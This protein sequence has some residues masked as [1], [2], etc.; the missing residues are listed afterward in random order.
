MTAAEKPSRSTASAPPAGTWFASA[1]RM[2]SEPSRRISLMQQADRIVIACRRIGRSW[3]TRVPRSRRFYARR[4]SRSGAHFVQRLPARQPAP[5]ARRLPEPARPPP[6][7]CTWWVIARAIVA[8]AHGK[9]PCSTISVS[10]LRTRKPRVHLRTGAGAA[11][12]EPD[13]PGVPAEE[14]GSGGAALG[15]GTEGNPLGRR[16]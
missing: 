13:R 9:K 12:P 15:F 8:F 2:T 11:R 6:M 4:S 5:V 10:R 16:Q 1:D 7:I 14:N 3:S